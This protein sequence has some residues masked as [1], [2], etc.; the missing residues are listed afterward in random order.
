MHTNNFEKEEKYI[1]HLA[2]VQ[3]VSTKRRRNH[4]E[5]GCRG[6]EHDIIVAVR[7]VAHAFGQ[8]DTLLDTAY[9]PSM[10]NISPSFPRAFLLLYSDSGSKLL[11]MISI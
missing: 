8:V 6:Q 11:Y 10:E 4:G 9:I 1:H 2:C 7:A 3:H 5:G